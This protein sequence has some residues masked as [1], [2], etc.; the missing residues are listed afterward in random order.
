[1]IFFSG[2]TFGRSTSLRVFKC[3]SASSS[4]TSFPQTLS[5]NE[6]AFLSA[7]F[8]LRSE[9]NRLNQKQCFSGESA[10]II[11]R[12]ISSSVTEEKKEKERYPLLRTDM[13][14]SFVHFQMPP[15]SQLYS[16]SQ[17]KETA[18]SFLTNAINNNR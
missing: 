1:M 17:S 14:V 4:A 12:R 18:V 3:C 8:L 15:A 5:T 16:S 6:P 10:V 2:K 9:M 13:S 11:P 7:M